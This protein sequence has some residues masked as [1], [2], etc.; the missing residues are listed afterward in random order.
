MQDSKISGGPDFTLSRQAILARLQNHTQ[1]VLNDK[2]QGITTQGEELSENIDDTRNILGT[3]A[4]GAAVGVTGLAK[5]TTLLNGVVNFVSAYDTTGIVTVGLG[6][7]VAVGYAV[8]T[9]LPTKKESR[10]RIEHVHT[11]LTEVLTKYFTDELD[12]VAR[13]LTEQYIQ[14]NEYVS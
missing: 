10:N 9:K 5:F 1:A 6:A 2:D 12:S 7:V 14:S 13:K 4:A 11:R 8:T 3:L